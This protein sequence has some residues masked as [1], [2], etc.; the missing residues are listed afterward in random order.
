NRT[1]ARGTRRGGAQP[2]AP[3]DRRRARRRAR[4]RE[5]RDSSL[6]PF[7]ALAHE[8]PADVGPRDGPDE[9]V[10]VDH[11]QPA[12]I[13][14]DHHRRGF[15]DLVIRADRDWGRDDAARD[16]LPREPPPAVEE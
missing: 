13:L 11:R 10:A 7:G 3:R 9:Q 5:R 2:R 6:Y 1:R 8:S 12:N 15:E 4:S 14:L 16:G